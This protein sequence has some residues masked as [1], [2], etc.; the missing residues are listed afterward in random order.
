MPGQPPYL[1]K[2]ARRGACQPT[3]GLGFLHGTLHACLAFAGTCDQSILTKGS[4]QYQDDA[5]AAARYVYNAGMLLD[6]QLDQE[7]QR[8]VSLLRFCSA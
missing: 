7:M 6:E 3:P 4:N 1:C 5:A 8:K 2:R